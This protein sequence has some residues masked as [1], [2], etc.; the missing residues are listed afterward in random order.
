MSSFFDEKQGAAKLK[1]GILSRYLPGW[2][3]KVGSASAGHRVAYFDLYAGDGSYESGE[4]GSPLLALDIAQKQAATRQMECYFVERERRSWEKLSAAVRGSPV[5]HQVLQGK[6]E[7]VLP[8]LLSRTRGSPLF[9]FCDPFGIGLPFRSLI[10]LLTRPG[11][12]GE[13]RKGPPTEVLLN[14]SRPG[15]YRNAGHLTSASQHPEYI[16]LRPKLVENVDRCLG[17]RWWQPIATSRDPDWVDQILDGYVRR[18]SDCGSGWSCYHIPVADDWDAKPIYHLVFLTQ[19]PDGLWLFNEALSSAT[20]AFYEWAHE[21]QLRLD[22]AEDRGARWSRAIADN[23]REMLPAGSFVVCQRMRDVFGSTLGLAREKHLR[24]GLR[25]LHQEGFVH[26]QPK[27]K[28]EQFTV[29]PTQQAARETRPTSVRQA[30][31]P[32]LSA[33]AR[34]TA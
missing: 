17:G 14:F 6:A 34:P 32:P 18:L 19:H 12:Q 25:I 30:P 10:D 16:K 24:A 33:S 26:D 28:L 21:G 11:T 29:R 31:V 15:I 27:G 9:A 8:A 13:W 22:T 7:E 5:I 2:V 4:Q 1:H 20:E 3:G 23:V